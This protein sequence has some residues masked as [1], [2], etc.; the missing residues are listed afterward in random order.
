MVSN[1]EAIMFFETRATREKWLDRFAA[2]NLP[3]NEFCKMHHIKKEMLIKTLNERMSNYKKEHP[4]KEPAVKITDFFVKEF[5]NGFTGWLQT[6]EYG[7]YETAL[8]EHSKLYPN[9]LI[10]HVGC[11]AHVRRKFHDAVKCGHG[12]AIDAEKAI[13]YIQKIYFIENRLREQNIDDEELVAERKMKIL[14]I[15]NEF[16]NWM[17]K[18]QPTV[19]PELKFGKALNYALNSWKH[20][21]N[22][23]ECPDI[24]LALN[25]SFNFKIRF[26]PGL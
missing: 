25:S 3:I 26:Q 11:M 6:D 17:V 8:E 9:D 10:I 22:Y 16:H 15:L 7:G 2:S 12:N 14:P 23:V 1:K 13:E 4:P 5:I 18:I 19:I 20:I 21:L 24:Y